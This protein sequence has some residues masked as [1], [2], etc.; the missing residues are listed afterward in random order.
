MTTTK[1]YDYMRVCLK[2]GRRPAAALLPVRFVGPLLTAR[3]GDARNGPPRAQPKSLAAAHFRFFRQT[4]NRLT[5]ISSAP[6]ASFILPLTFNYNYNPANQRTKDTLADGSYWVYGYDSLGQVTNACKYFANGTPVAG[7]QFDYT[8]DTIGNRTQI[9]AGGNQNGQN[10]RLA[11]Y[12][13]NNVNQITNRDVAPDVDVMGASILTN[14]V[15]VNGTNAYR[16]QEYFRAQLAVNNTN[17]AL[18][19]NI[20][21]S[22]G[23]NVTGNVYVAQEPESFKYDADGNLTNDG[24]WAYTWDGENRLIA[25]TTNNLV[26]PPYHLTFSYD[27]QGRRIQKVSATNG[28]TIGTYNFLYDGWNLVAEVGTSGA[29]VRSYTWGTDLSGSQQGAGG[30]GGLLEVS[31][32][33]TAITNCFPAYDGN[34]NIAGLINAVD[35]TIAA[36]YEYGPFGEVIRNSGSM[37]KNNPLRFSTKYQDDESDLLYYGYRYY[38]PS[39]GTWPNRD[40]LGESG[41]RLVTT[42]KQPFVNTRSN[43]YLKLKNWL[44]NEPGNP[45]T[46]DFI[47]NNPID[48]RDRLGLEIDWQN[49]IDKMNQIIDSGKDIAKEIQ[50]AIK[51]GKLNGLTP[52]DALDQFFGIGQL[53]DQ[54][55]S[56]LEAFPDTPSCLKMVR[57]AKGQNKCA[58][59]DAAS[60]CALD[61]GI[62]TGSASVDTTLEKFF[63][64][65]ICKQ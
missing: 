62:A 13:V 17:S 59:A 21:V 32:H 1:Q 34:G 60:E 35:G 39:T 2:N 8:F 42:G 65:K 61:L 63:T 50:D 33:G 6:S 43:R 29:L 27:Y 5:Q 40:P 38:K 20:I 51:E 44:L 48:H 4:Q 22:G 10:L 47:A 49:V 54:M 23:Q 58:C 19:T 57:A 11:N 45:N 55:V 26:G 18:W 15:T 36:N 24:R 3:C 64:K 30:V 25:M 16:N 41:F 14:A 52:K 46:Y 9:L 31:Y 53:T 37:A 7:Q 56:V 12:I 28:V